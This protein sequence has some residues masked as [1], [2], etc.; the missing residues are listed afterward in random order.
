MKRIPVVIMLSGVF[1]IAALTSRSRSHGSSRWKRT[2]T[3]MWVLDVK[4]QRVVADAV[5]GRRDG[6]H[7]GRGQPGG[8]P[9][10]LVAV[11]GGGVDEL[12]R[13]AAAH[14]IALPATRW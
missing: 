9:Q 14:A 3:A 11:A 7:V 5:H 12:D 10:A 2:E 4:S 1:G 8:A 6:Q 13:S